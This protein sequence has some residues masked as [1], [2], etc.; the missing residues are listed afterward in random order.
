MKRAAGVLILVATGSLFSL[1]RVRTVRPVS[2]QT[3]NRG[4]TQAGQKTFI[5]YCA[6]CHSA[7]EGQVLFGPSLYAEM[8]KPHPKKTTAEV[9]E[10]LINGKGKMPAFADRLSPA[11]MDNLVAYLRTL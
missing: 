5:Q 10:I 11:D 3:V 4:D 9:H 6:Q 7:N 2:A 1:S 8:R